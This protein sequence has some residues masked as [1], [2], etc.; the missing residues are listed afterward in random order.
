MQRLEAFSVAA[1]IAFGSG[2]GIG[3]ERGTRGQLCAI[4][5]ACVGAGLAVLMRLALSLLRG[6][7][8]YVA[9]GRRE[10]D[11]RCSRCA[12]CFYPPGHRRLRLPEQWAA[13]HKVDRAKALEDRLRLWS[14]GDYP[15]GWAGNGV[16][17]RRGCWLLWVRLP[18]RQSH[19]WSSTG[20][21]GASVGSFGGA[22]R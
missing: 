8:R 14:G 4:V 16:G 18:E 13:G 15:R 22:D 20:I 11:W 1:W 10:C 21:V 19:G 7:G 17:V 6:P 3:T 2:R 12:A 9:A 5:C